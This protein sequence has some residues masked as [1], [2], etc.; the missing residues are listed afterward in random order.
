MNWEPKTV[1]DGFKCV[2]VKK[3]SEYCAFFAHVGGIIITQKKTVIA[4]LLVVSLN[5]AFSASKYTVKSTDNDW[6]IAH[7]HHLTVGQLHEANPDVKWNALHKGQILRIPSA[8]S[9]SHQTSS[10]SKNHHSAHEASSSSGGEVHKVR[11]NDNDFTIAKKN[12]IT[13]KELHHL[14][15]DVNWNRLHP[16]QTIRV[17][18][19]SHT[20]EG[21]ASVHSKSSRVVSHHIV[22][23]GYATINGSNV[24]LRRKPSTSS[25]KVTTVGAGTVGRVLDKQDGWAKMRFPKG[26]EAWVRSDLLI[27]AK[28]W[29]EDSGTSEH[30]S[31][32][33]EV[34]QSKRK[35]TRQEYYASAP[36]KGGLLKTALGY[37]GVPYVSGGTSRG[38]FD[39]SGLTYTVFRKYGMLLPRTAYEQ[40][41]EGE[42]IDR[43]ELQKGDLVFFHT[44][45]SREVNHVGIYIGNNNFIHAS[46]G[47]GQVRV[48]SLDESYYND[49]FVEG[50]R[51]SGISGATKNDSGRA[52]DTTAHSVR[53]H[54]SRQHETTHHRSSRKHSSSHHS[55]THHTSAKKKHHHSK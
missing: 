12:G 8:H 47:S 37:Q 13:V 16:G 53:R 49:R 35:G 28:N 34:A 30:H 24:T 41:H 38:G 7:K 1:L 55:K 46:S 4:G 21:H 20:S 44:L 19:S 2:R 48:S 36:A 18:G 52:G 31:P 29:N 50:R 45:G 3:G 17:S 42:R 32:K 25:D 33:K 11:G 51:I 9:A 54:R 40:S 5:L 43:S 15:P 10:S 22:E 39:C 14:N 27:A 26:T 23:G 6:I